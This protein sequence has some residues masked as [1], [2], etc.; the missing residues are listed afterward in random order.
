M[1]LCRPDPLP[2]ESL[3]SWRQ[4]AA[5]ENGYR[6]FP[7]GPEL[8]RSD[9]DVG[10]SK[11]HCWLAE[12]FGRNAEMVS[13]MSLASFSK[14]LGADAGGRTRW[15]VPLRY[16]RSKVPYGPAYCP[17][18]LAQGERPYFRKHWRLAF[19][20]ACVLHGC[21]LLESCTHCGLLVWPSCSTTPALFEEAQ[22]SLGDCPRCGFRL[23]EAST[24]PGDSIIH[25]T[26]TLRHV[27]DAGHAPL[28]GCDVVPAREYFDALATV[29]NL[30]LRRRV[31][32]AIVGSESRWSGLAEKGLATSMG[33]VEY[34]PIEL[35]SE[36]VTS[37]VGVLAD[38]P[39]NFL[40]FCEAC[41][42]S[43]QHFSDAA[44]PA[45]PWL[46][47]EVDQRCRRKPY[48]VPDEL[49]DAAERQLA[50]AG[51]EPT[52]QNLAAA[53]GSDWCEA[54]ARRFRPSVRASLGDLDRLIGALATHAAARHRR[55]SSLF[56]A[57]RDVAVVGAAV[58]LQVPVAVSALQSLAECRSSL[59][60][61]ALLSGAAQRLHALVLTAT[62]KSAFLAVE[63]WPDHPDR[64]GVRGS[65][66]VAR[67]ATR[68]FNALCRQL[69][70]QR[71]TA[72]FAAAIQYLEGQTWQ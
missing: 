67:S 32:S 42:L 68:L 48:R 7:S 4:H 22:A 18:C 54:V 69:N 1:Y 31:A 53:V 37:A 29:S 55:R 28:S 19:E 63:L 46:L 36:V 13:G 43:V 21:M 5:Q 24:L 66:D 27:L 23:S 16:S 51:I 52:K 41:R 10:S 65:C 20:C 25:T 49:V 58:L 35:R 3:S 47:E 40:A 30:F 59:A 6:L 71:S 8:R 34:L 26:V 56:T 72:A 2:D 61:I 9:P 33:R 64:N 12:R 15:L 45:P 62:E 17:I 39:T 38:W 44:T 57:L 11:L 14:S 50:L 60:S 70:V